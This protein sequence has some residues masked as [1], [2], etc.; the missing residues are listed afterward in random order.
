M[1]ILNKKQLISLTLLFLVF[2]ATIPSI[3]FAEDDRSYS[4]NQANIDLF[5]QPNGLLNVKEKYYYSFS[6]TYNGVYRDI[7]LKSGE[8]IDNIKVTSKGAYSSYELIKSGDMDRIKI[9]LY[10]DPQKTTPITN[11]NV[12]VTI[13]YDF[14]NVIKIYN[15]IGELQYKLWGESWEV[16]VNEVNANIH[17]ASREDVKYWLNPPYF[18]Q[19]SGWDGSVLKIKTGPISSGDY[20]EVRVAIPLSQFNNPVFAKKLNEDGLD[21]IEKIQE[22][23]QNEINFKNMLYK[24]LAILMILSIFIPVLIYLKYGREPKI[25]YDAKY[26]RELPTN[27]PPALVNAIS[28]KGFGKQVGE[29]DMDGYRATIMDLIN[30]KYLILVDTEPDNK[31]KKSINLKTN[32]GKK[33]DDL[34]KF[35]KDVIVFLSKFEVE[36]VISLDKMKKDLKKPENAKSFKTLYDLWMLDLKNQYLKKN[37]LEKIFI[38]KGNDYLKIYGVLAIII[39]ALVF[40]FSAINPLPSAIYS[41]IASIILGLVGIISLILPSKIAGRWTAHGMEYNA[42][43]MNFKR[44]IKDFSL[45]KEYPPESIAIWNHYLVYATALGVADQVRKNM[46]IHLPKDELNNSDIYLFHYYGGYALLSSNLSTGMVAANPNNGGS[47]GMGGVGGVG[48]GSGGGGGGAF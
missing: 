12:Q 27:D 23:Y 28:G 20:M 25:D 18:V 9:Y 38:D 34:K 14:I 7:P 48:G 40:F 11:K 29:P 45:I 42:K 44:F 17:L 19:K 3:S 36:G 4:I 47:G 1:I 24:L 32:P 13:E 15:D 5:V 46:E 8:R 21:K 39:G 30:R 16:D 41:L 22:D 10:S 37:E 33:F 43:W 6:G 2:I 31:G 26:E 35:E